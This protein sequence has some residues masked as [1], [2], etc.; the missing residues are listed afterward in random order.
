MAKKKMSEEEK[1][2]LLQRL[3]ESISEGTNE[4]YARAREIA[5]TLSSEDPAIL[6]RILAALSGESGGGGGDGG[7]GGGG[8]A[9][10]WNNGAL[11][12]GIM[13]EDPETV[14]ARLTEAC[15]V[16]ALSDERFIRHGVN[17]S[18]TVET[19]LQVIEVF[20]GPAAPSAPAVLSVRCLLNLLEAWPDT[21]VHIMSAG[22]V[23]V[24]SGVLR[25]SLSP[26][27]NPCM[28]FDIELV[29]TALSFLNRMARDYPAEVRAGGALGLLAG[30]LDFFDLSKQ[31]LILAT[32]LSA[33]RGLIAGTGAAAAEVKTCFGG[34][35]FQAAVGALG[36]ENPSMRATAVSLLLALV[37]PLAGDRSDFVR[38][39]YTPAVISATLAVV[40]EAAATPDATDAGLVANSSS[41]S[42]VV[43]GGGDDDDDD[44][45]HNNNNNGID[46]AAAAREDL[47]TPVKAAELLEAAFAAAQETYAKVLLG[48]G[49]QGR[50]FMDEVTTCLESLAHS[51]GKSTTKAMLVEHTLDALAR[52]LP[53]LPAAWK[54]SVPS[55]KDK[56]KGSH[57]SAFGETKLRKKRKHH[58]SGDPDNGET[59]PEGKTK[60]TK[61]A[62]EAKPKERKVFGLLSFLSRYTKKGTPPVAQS[63]VPPSP[64]AAE[65][66]AD[67]SEGE[68]KEDEEKEKK[69]AKTEKRKGEA[70]EGKK[71][72]NGSEEEE[73][74][75]PRARFG[76]AMVRLLAELGA[77]ALA[78]A[79]ERVLMVLS[80]A[81]NGLCTEAPRAFRRAFGGD[82]V[83]QVSC[84]VAEAMGL[85]TLPCVCCSL[86]VAGFFLETL[87]R[88]G[89][90]QA[91]RREG[92][93]HQLRM[94]ASAAN[95]PGR[96]KARVYA[97][98][99]ADTVGTVDKASSV[100]TASFTELVA[101]VANTLPSS[102]ASP[103]QK[104]A[105]ELSR[106]EA[107]AQ[108]V[109]L[110]GDEAS[111]LSV[112]DAIESD[113]M[114]ALVLY[115][116]GAR[117]PADLRRPRDSAAAAELIA[118]RL[119][120]LYRHMDAQSPS[121]TT[122]D[123]SGL[124]GL[125]LFANKVLTKCE[126]LPMPTSNSAEDIAAT[127]KMA[128]SLKILIRRDPE[129]HTLPEFPSEAPV[130]IDASAVGRSIQDYI[131]AKLT[132]AISDSKVKYSDSNSGYRVV[133]KMNGVVIGQNQ[134]FIDVL[135]TSFYSTASAA[136]TAPR[137]LQRLVNLNEG[138]S[139][140]G[141]TGYADLLRSVQSVTYRLPTPHELEVFAQ[142]GESSAFLSGEQL[143]PQQPQ[144][145]AEPNATV[146]AISV[147]DVIPPSADPLVYS[148]QRYVPMIELNSVMAYT[149]VL[150]RVL[151]CINHYGISSG[152]VSAGDGAERGQRYAVPVERKAFV[153]AAVAEKLTNCFKHI[154]SVVSGHFPLWCRAVPLLF[155]FVLPDDLRRL[156][157][158]CNYCGVSRSLG[159]VAERYPEIPLSKELMRL[160]ELTR[161]RFSVPRSPDKYIS[162]A[163]KMA[164]PGRSFLPLFD[165][166]FAGEAGTGLGP[167]TEFFA[168]LGQ[169]FA[170]ADLG[171]WFQD[172]PPGPDG[173][174]SSAEG[175]Y[176][177]PRAPAA[178]AD[179]DKKIL[180]LFTLLGTF[181]AKAIL[182]NRILGVP[183]SQPFLKW[184]TGA[185]LERTDIARISPAIGK[186][187]GNFLDVITAAAAAAGNE[188]EDPF[189]DAMIPFELPGVP[190]YPLARGLAEGY[191]DSKEDD[192][193]VYITKENAR[194]YAERVVDGFFGTGVRAQLC[195]FKTG[196]DRVLP[197][198]SLRVLSLEAL[199]GLVCGSQD[200]A[201]DAQAILDS[202]KF[203]HGYS[204]TSRVVRDLA[205]VM[206][207]FSEEDRRHFVRF[208]TGSPRLPAGGFSALNPRL[209]ISK[210]T[211]DTPQEAD[212]YLPSVN[213]CFHNIK[214]TE[215]SSK[216]VLRKKLLCAIYDGQ[217]AFDFS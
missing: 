170:R 188:E 138:E 103:Q 60:G 217:G 125:V 151:R 121:S 16:L 102:S 47:P 45:D 22:G 72:E 159:A 183:F 135:S 14:Y 63:P 93:V 20:S 152:A 180:E 74:N 118:Q 206:E 213:C 67:D 203:E 181:T 212:M 104:D 193:E 31:E 105:D 199:E 59:G 90:V 18:K 8:L 214:F 21:A 171:L 208:L 211:A 44:D 215:Y 86:R 49:E 106:A 96:K 66:N 15:E 127:L 56:S 150:L 70:A 169:E 26:E 126:T 168:L 160:T 69:R 124:A 196:F 10:R 85:G 97:A 65:D 87:G 157:F 77:Q 2:E 61:E 76:C 79:K 145:A 73:E 23:R 101:R 99:L 117:S 187:F 34:A 75:T 162:S 163:A 81:I 19:L 130:G 108:L 51:S 17:V 39:Y 200:A 144:T 28:D 189:E 164:S 30:I 54:S 42:S 191:N 205:Q 50:R 143:Q 98:W 62:A 37:R 52:L 35:L 201:W 95:D 53:P 84:F 149:L 185:P 5:R 71:E 147:A 132:P 57:S 55:T 190:D 7:G 184:M 33:A 114:Q 13:G 194:A 204:R 36:N 158:M 83:A 3:R 207:E 179:K 131:W 82:A 112:Y 195:A 32:A 216:E 89:V 148:L 165:V 156:A 64:P 197:M 136:S 11:L 129:E 40:A 155:G 116:L 91:W 133:V 24:V 1:E 107:V 161:T 154:P 142:E 4:G 146:E 12:D 6:L 137:G 109:R 209:T 122:S 139:E 94:V 176:P 182:D 141:G 210:K 111:G 92:V 192:N 166:A 140:V 46:P 113:F 123:S 41:S 172:A 167:T 202:A 48:N 175:L 80:Q 119:G 43:T 174:I 88:D 178:A 29:E 38:T 134:P 78:P 9:A 27:L 100:G 110:A 120:S 177:L 173:R 68:G 115:F 186:T 128:R 153:N 58:S 25:N 198:E